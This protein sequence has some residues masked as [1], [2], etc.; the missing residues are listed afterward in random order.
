MVTAPAGLLACNTHVAISSEI[1]QLSKLVMAFVKYQSHSLM[2]DSNGNA[3][4]NQC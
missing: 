2:T 4:C 1:Q 3:L